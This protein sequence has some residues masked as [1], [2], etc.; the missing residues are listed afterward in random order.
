METNDD[1]FYSIDGLAPSYH[2]HPGEILGEELKERGI[3][4]KTFAE[5]IGIQPSHL[6]AL[7][8]GARSFTPSVS[9]KIESGLPGVS[10]DYWMRMQESY[11]A[12]VRRR[13]VN[14]SRLVFG[15]IQQLERNTQALAEPEVPYGGQLQLK[16]SI[17][18]DDLE[19]LNHIAARLGWIIKQG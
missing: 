19:L 9:A 8:H 1:K 4:Q 18:A 7:I 16:I 3:S 10:A 6:C 13:K 12:D 14:P 11:N 15:Y 17:P 2:V 5:K